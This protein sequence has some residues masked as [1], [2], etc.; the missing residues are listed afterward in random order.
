MRFKKLMNEVVNIT[1]LHKGWSA[2]AIKYNTQIEQLIAQKNEISKKIKQLENERNKAH[3]KFDSSTG[4]AVMEIG[5]K[6]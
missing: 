5:I 3:E 4:K 6:Q 1:K 2:I